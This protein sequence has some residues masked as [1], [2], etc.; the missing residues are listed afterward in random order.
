MIHF[1]FFLICCVLIENKLT[2]DKYLRTNILRRTMRTNK[3]RRYKNP[4]FDQKESPPPP[5][6]HGTTPFFFLIPHP[7][8][9]RRRE[10]LPFPTTYSDRSSRFSKR[11][12]KHSRANCGG[13]GRQRTP[14][15]EHRR[16]ERI[17]LW[18]RRRRGRGSEP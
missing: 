7:L 18:R 10:R 11:P 3:L 5:Q 15:G 8:A 17:P 2:N 4:H 12:V 14:A 16:A 9:A 13:H 1:S 6:R